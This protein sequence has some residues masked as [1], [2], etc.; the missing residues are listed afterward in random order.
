MSQHVRPSA[1]T[2]V[3]RT[4]R[5]SVS[6]MS[7]DRYSYHRR[8]TSNSGLG[9]HAQYQPSY[10]PQYQSSSLQYA[11]MQHSTMH[12]TVWTLPQAAQANDTGNIHNTRHLGCLPPAP[13]CPKHG[14]P[15]W[16]PLPLPIRRWSNEPPSSLHAASSSRSKIQKSTRVSV[17]MAQAASRTR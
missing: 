1:A 6:T 17:R 12:I 7:G 5:V 2:P 10:N 4:S 14:T 9:A 11:P 8:A 3:R 16:P 15:A 13:W